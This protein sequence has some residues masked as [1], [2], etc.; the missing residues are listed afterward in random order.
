V[1]PLHH[2]QQIRG[3]LE[4]LASAFPGVRAALSRALPRCLRQGSRA[5]DAADLYARRGRVVARSLG[6]AHAPACA[7]CAA[8][9]ICDGP[10]A[11]SG[12]GPALRPIRAQAAFTDPC[13]YI[14]L[15]DKVVE[16]EDRSWALPS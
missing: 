1:E 16:E 15:Q 11:A 7:G 2:V 9:G 14:R 3:P 6:F 8:R 5:E 12:L 10:H 13:R 4:G